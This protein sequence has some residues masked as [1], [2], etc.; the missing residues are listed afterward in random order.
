MNQRKNDTDGMFAILRDIR[1][2]V[3]TVDERTADLPAIRERISDLP[4]M[5]RLLYMML[6]GL[7]LLGALFPVTVGVLIAVLKNG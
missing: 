5:R 4:A 7:V 1:A 3:D 6:G 2:K